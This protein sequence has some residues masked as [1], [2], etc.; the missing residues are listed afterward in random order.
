MAR[1]GEQNSDLITP[2]SSMASREQTEL[3]FASEKLD[4]VPVSQVQNLTER[5]ITPGRNSIIGS[6]LLRCG[7]RRKE[8]ISGFAI[9]EGTCPAGVAK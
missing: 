8:G 9:R 1:V 3:V 7:W 2:A 4:V 5:R 6:L